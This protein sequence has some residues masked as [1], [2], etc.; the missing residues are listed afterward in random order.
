MSLKALRGAAR[1]D[2][3]AAACVALLVLVVLVAVLAP[4]IA[5]HSPTEVNLSSAYLGPS[6][7]HPMG[8]DASGRD[9]LSRVIWGAGSSL[10]GPLGVIALAIGLGGSMRLP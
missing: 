6:L 8:T 1:R 2:R 5:P 4:L 3:L 9:I 10:L 7:E